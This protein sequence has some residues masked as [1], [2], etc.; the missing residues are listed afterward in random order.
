MNVDRPR[1]RPPLIGRVARLAEHVELDA[2]LQRVL[3]EVAAGPDIVA[4]VDVEHD[5]DAGSISFTPGDP[6]LS[7]MP[8]LVQLELLP[9]TGLLPVGCPSPSQRWSSMPGVIS[10]PICTMSGRAP[11]AISCVIASFV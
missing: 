7:S 11:A 3:D 5:R 6:A 9:L 10:F 8:S 4:A 2:L 1:R